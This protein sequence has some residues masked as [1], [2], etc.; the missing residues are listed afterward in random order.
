MTK[1]VIKLEY[2]KET[3]NLTGI[4]SSLILLSDIEK[5]SGNINKAIE[6]LNKAK[7]I[8]LNKDLKDFSLFLKS[9]EKYLK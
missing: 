3:K 4:I 1:T 7:N 9:I 8:C 2:E 5:K 6:L